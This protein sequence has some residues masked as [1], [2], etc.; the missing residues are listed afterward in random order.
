DD[1]AADWAEAVPTS[2][3]VG[4]S[5]N[6]VP[7]RSFALP[8]DARDSDLVCGERRDLHVTSDGLTGW[9]ADS[10]TALEVANGERM[11]IVDFALTGESDRKLDERADE[12]AVDFLGALRGSRAGRVEK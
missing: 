9:Q 8:T 7:E 5:K 3:D 11:V 12:L 1:S 10:L 2:A 6:V 4:F